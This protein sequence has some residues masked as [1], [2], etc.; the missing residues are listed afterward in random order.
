MNSSAN[1]SEVFLSENGCVSK[2]GKNSKLFKDKTFQYNLSGESETNHNEAVNLSTVK[3]H[4]LTEGLESLNIED[5]RCNKYEARLKAK[6]THEDTGLSEEKQSPYCSTSSGQCFK[7]RHYRPTFVS[8]SYPVGKT[9]EQINIPKGVCRYYWQNGFCRYGKFCRY[10]HTP[11]QFKPKGPTT[12]KNKRRLSESFTNT[13]KPSSDLAEEKTSVEKEHEEFEEV[14]TDHKNDT[15]LQFCTNTVV[16]NKQNI[17]K[18][19]RNCYFFKH[20]GFCH[21]GDRCYFRHSNSKA[22]QAK[23]S[24]HDSKKASMKHYEISNDE[25]LMGTESLE[26]QTLKS[27]ASSELPVCN[28]SIQKEC[29]EQ[30]SHTEHEKP[31]G[32]STSSVKKEMLGRCQMSVPLLRKKLVLESLSPDDLMELREMEIMQLK[33]RF[34]HYRQLCDVNNSSESTFLVRFM[35]TDPDWPFDLNSIDLEVVFEKDYPQKPCKVMVVDEDD[36]LPEQLLRFLNKNIQKWLFQRNDDLQKVGEVGLTFR[37]FLRWLDKSLEDMFIEGL[38]MVKREREAQAAGIEFVPFEELSHGNKQNIDGDHTYEDNTTELNQTDY[39]KES[40]KL[41]ENN[42]TQVLEIDGRENTGSSNEVLST[43]K[44]GTEVKLHNLQLGENVATLVC[45]KIDVTVQCSRCKTRHEISTPSRHNNVIQ[46]TKCHHVQQVA[47]RASILHH[48]SPVLGYLDLV[49]CQAVD[50]PLMKCELNVCCLNCN[51]QMT[52]T[53][54][55]YGQATNTWCHF[56]NVK[57]A[58]FADTVKFSQLQQTE[59]FDKGQVQLIR[60]QRKDKIVKDPVIQDGK[61]LPENGTCKHY[62]KS[63]R[64]LR[65]PCCGKAYPCDLCHDEKEMD[66][67]ME[68]AT[69]MI[70]GFCA[71]EQAYASDKPCKRCFSYMTKK[72]TAYWEGGKGCREKSHMSRD[73]KKKYSGKNKTVSRKQSEKTKPSGKQK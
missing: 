46:C 41:E 54:I 40:E 3:S 57:F 28:I 73:D 27:D 32:G 24:L 45:Q 48:F 69:R 29:S 59:R 70:C 62:K 51:K 67:D 2:E 39:S 11:T 68:L 35:P 61:P 52:M 4:S 42:K 65:F 47:F 44:R 21:Y 16:E 22:L 19:R 14:N 20:Y 5:S 56:C 53:G 34:P 25:K 17:P 18:K 55:H 15:C 33:K 43:P 9:E 26:L 31:D 6:E 7:S 49:G 37:P 60:L 66:H 23:D 72:R 13:C 8:K 10:R 12:Q 63:F 38:R 50:L 30:S 36:V 64:W 58:I 1:Q 71:K